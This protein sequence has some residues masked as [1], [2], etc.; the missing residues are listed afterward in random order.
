M[1]LMKRGG[2]DPKDRW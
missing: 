1:E 2:R